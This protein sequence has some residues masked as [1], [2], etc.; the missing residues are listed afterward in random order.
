MKSYRVRAL[1][2]VYMVSYLFLTNVVKRCD[3]IPANRL[4]LKNPPQSWVFSVCP[5]NGAIMDHRDFLE[6]SNNGHGQFRSS[7]LFLL[8]PVINH[9]RHLNRLLWPEIHI[10]FRLKNWWNDSN[11]GI[12]I[13][14]RHTAISHSYY[15]TTLLSLRRQTRNEIIIQRIGKRATFDRFDVCMKA[16][17]SHR[18]KCAKILISY[19]ARG[20]AVGWGTAL[21]VGRWR[22]RFPD[23]AFFIDI[24]LP[25]ALWPCGWLSL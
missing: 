25:A 16:E 12:V 15:K 5:S 19:G 7:A 24:I 13:S 22:V 3:I 23:G 17:T 2:V 4:I 6:Y 9:I 18:K 11:A 21:Q 10:K 1:H 20:S 8:S 14:S